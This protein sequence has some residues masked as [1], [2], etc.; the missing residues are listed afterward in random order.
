M[1]SVAQYRII[2]SSIGLAIV[3]A[4]FNGLVRD[5]LEGFLPSTEVEDLLRSPGRITGYS[6]DIQETIRGAFGSG[7]NL[8]LKIL[9]GLASLQIP[10]A[11]MIWE[12][13]QIKT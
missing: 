9:A 7:Y 1:G 12:K 5:R 13:N 2:G 4:A 6:E 3:T 11:L 8:Q 10:A